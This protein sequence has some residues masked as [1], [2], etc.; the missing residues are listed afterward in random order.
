MNIRR[1]FVLA[2]TLQLSALAAFATAQRTFVSAA[3]GSDTNPCSR[4]APCRNF[5][6]ALPATSPGG[7]IIV[8]DSGGYG[9]VVISQGVTIKAPSGVYA[10]ITV[11]GN[12]VG[13]SINV[14][15]T[16][17]VV[18]HGLTITGLGG[19][20]GISWTGGSDLHVENCVV[21]N[22]AN[23]Y[24]IF[25]QSDTQNNNYTFL[26]VS[27][28]VIRNAA[29]MIYALGGTVNAVH[30]RIHVDESRLEGTGGNQSGLFGSGNVRA[31]IT[32]SVVD[33]MLA[34]IFALNSGTWMT[35][36]QCSISHSAF[37][38]D[39]DTGSFVRISRST[40]TQNQYGLYINGGTIETLGNN[41]IHGN[42]TDTNASPTTISPM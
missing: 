2:I 32:R 18:L 11:Q 20:T 38:V 29:F 5:A 13:A 22:F 14:P 10:G 36:D 40:L 17:S 33:G 28:T 42:T 31:T 35:V 9:S 16:D 3:T 21:S 7:E 6:A 37:G 8:L 39:A 34:G 24:G 23:G 19:L 26:F 4:T 12:G 1:A 27:N 25:D 41:T 15:T 30:D